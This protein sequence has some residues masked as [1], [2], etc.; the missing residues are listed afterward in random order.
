MKEIGETR[1]PPKAGA[2]TDAG[3]TPGIRPMT[4]SEG[5]KK[6]YAGYLFVL[7]VVLGMLL[8]TFVPMLSSLIYSFCEYDVVN[9]PKFIG[10]QNYIRA[11][12][13][14]WEETGN[15]LKVT[16]LYAIVSIPLEIVLS[17]LLAVML[18]Q[19]IRGVRFF[20]T[21]YYLP[22]L[23]PGIVSSMLWVNIFDMQYGVANH[24]LNLVGLPSYTWFSSSDSAMITLIFTTLFGLGA[25]LLLWVSAI[26]GI[27]TQYYEVAA[28]EGA[29]PVT[30][31]LKITVPMCTA[32]IFYKLITGIIAA[33]Q[34]FTSAFV[35]TNSRA[36]PDGSLDF[37]SVVIYRKAFDMFRM[38]YASALAWVLFLIIAVLTAIVFVTNKNWV[39]YGEE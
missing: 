16:F 31:L 8:F 29:G 39:Y 34:V 36:T 26:K 7:P 37:Y 10:F 4:F 28:L 18:S 1:N 35:I 33:L 11:F 32:T 3:K 21:L 30:R 22:C 38:G 2:G 20:R 27:D 6:Y 9:P 23:I 14:Y 12:T 25:S 13:V 24:L 15:S 5:F 19:N 17:F